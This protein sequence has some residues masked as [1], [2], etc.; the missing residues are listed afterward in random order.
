MAFQKRRVFQGMIWSLRKSA[1]YASELS[2]CELC[3]HLSDLVCNIILYK[4]RWAYLWKRF[5]NIQNVAIQANI[6][7]RRQFT[8]LI[9]RL[10]Q[11]VVVI[12]NH[13][14]PNAI[15]FNDCHICKAFFS[16]LL[17]RFENC[18]QCPIFQLI[19]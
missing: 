5:L 18:T 3:W 1:N 6:W 15:F 17:H 2:P 13:A 12:F 11:S 10:L 9:T 8:K 16:F 14:S 19:F 4:I 7:W